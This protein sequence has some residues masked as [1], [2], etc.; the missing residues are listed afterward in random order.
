MSGSKPS[1]EELLHRIDD[2]L[3]V[4]SL[5]S[6]DL[7]KV[8]N[9]M[10]EITKSKTSLSLEARKYGEIQAAFPKVLLEMLSFE[11]SEMYVMIRPRQFLR[12]EDFAKIASVSRDLG[13]EYISAGKDSHFRIPKKID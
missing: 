11:E 12:S 10:R 9:E 4:L 1:I 6:R 13:G 3:S 8:S 5:I 2:L 7:I